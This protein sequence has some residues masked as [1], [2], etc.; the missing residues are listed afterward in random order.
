M[1]KTLGAAS[2]H[3]KLVWIVLR[4][5]ADGLALLPPLGD[6]A[7]AAARGE[8][9]LDTSQTLPVNGEFA[10]HGS[11]KQCA[12]AFNRGELSVLPACSTA[13]R[14]RSH[15]DAQKVLD[16]GTADPGVRTGWLN[17]TLVHLPG[18]AIAV[19]QNIPLSLQGD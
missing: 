15:F 3:R 13:Y 4:G 2:T 19:G 16:N 6:P 18:S 17:R 1:E 5:A 9:A 14:A 12:Q 11:L 8:L 7:Y 10:L